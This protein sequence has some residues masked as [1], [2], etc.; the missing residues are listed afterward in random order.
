MSQNHES[1]F[2]QSNSPEFFDAKRMVVNVG[3]EVRLS[4]K[5]REKIYLSNPAADR[6]I[7]LRGIVKGF[8]QEKVLVEEVYSTPPPK[9]KCLIWNFLLIG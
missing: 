8:R 6:L 4:E 1:E 3:D 9:E 2:E 7:T 5:G